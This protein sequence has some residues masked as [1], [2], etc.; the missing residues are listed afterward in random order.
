MPVS[1][2]EAAAAAVAV[3]VQ[4]QLMNYCLH[5]QPTAAQM[6]EGILCV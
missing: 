6:P 1:A 3:V 2:A 4:A 5:T